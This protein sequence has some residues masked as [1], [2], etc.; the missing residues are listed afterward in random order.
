MRQCASNLFQCAFCTLRTG[1][2]GGT[3]EKAAES[4][5]CCNVQCTPAHFGNSYTQSPKLLNRSFLA[6]SC[7]TLF[8]KTHLWK[9]LLKPIV[10]QKGRAPSYLPYATSATPGSARVRVG[11]GDLVVEERLFV[12]ACS[13]HRL[14]LRVACLVLSMLIHLYLP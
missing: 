1:H 8:R 3:L 6:I 12:D 9:R 13:L 14:A 5:M 11:V 10:E 2:I 4:P 7:E